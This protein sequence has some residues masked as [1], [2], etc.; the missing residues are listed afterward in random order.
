M[1]GFVSFSLRDGDKPVW[2]L[3]GCVDREDASRNRPRV[4]D[5]VPN[6]LR[7]HDDC[8]RRYD[9]SVLTDRYFHRPP[10]HD[11]EDLI[12]VVEHRGH[13]GLHQLRCETAERVAGAACGRLAGGKEDET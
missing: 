12:P 10:G 4:R 3:S 13:T 9:L 7:D 2:V 11:D 6:A 5:V 1:L 8:S